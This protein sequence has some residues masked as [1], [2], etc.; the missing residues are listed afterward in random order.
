MKRIDVAVGIITDDIGRVLVGQRIVKDDYF[1][2]WEF[3]GGKFE[4][5]EQAS[6]AL[7]RELR[8]ELG[9]EVHAC[10]ELMLLEHNY[11][12]RKVRLHVLTVTNYAGEVCSVE[13]QAIQWLALSELQ[14]LDFLAGNQAII[15]RLHLNL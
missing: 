13:G 8:E 5:G 1:E 10:D 9:R 3:P 11:P 12:D 15:E 6:T 2:K 14:N 7:V 4:A